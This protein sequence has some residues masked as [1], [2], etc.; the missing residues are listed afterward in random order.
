MKTATIILREAPLKYVQGD[1][2]GVDKGALFALKNNLTVHMAVG[3]FDSVNESELN[4]IKQ[5]CD[6][7]HILNPIKDMTDFEYAL[8]LCNDYEK[9]IVIGGLGNRR[10]HE[11]LIVRKATVDQRITVYDDHN[12][13]YSLTKGQWK[14]SK[15]DYQY[16]SLF[17]I[18]NSVI[19]L[20][21]F[22][23]PLNTFET[24]GQEDML[25]SNEIQNDIGMIHI[26]KGKLLIIQAND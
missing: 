10:D 26:H 11:Y 12:K 1:I 24:K 5:H 6:N 7:T 21:G 17:P 2:F 3:D 20:E 4:Y 9:I 15:D 22:K 13:I 14:I 19:S 16:I 18:E 23:Y 25:T 8:N